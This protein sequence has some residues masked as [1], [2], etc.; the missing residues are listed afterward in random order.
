MVVCKKELCPRF[1]CIFLTDVIECVVLSVGAGAGVLAS[2]IAVVY[3]SPSCDVA[4]SNELNNFFINRFDDCHNFVI[5]GDF[6]YP[7]IDW[8]N[9]ICDSVVFEMFF[10]CM[11]DISSTQMVTACTRNNAI[12]DL[13][14]GSAPDIV[15]NVQVIANFP[16]ND[17]KSICASID[18]SA[19]CKLH[20]SYEKWMLFNKVK[21][22]LLYD[23]LRTVQMGCTISN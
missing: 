6:N 7:G 21:V 15:K 22:Q 20:I 12:L 4:Q 8:V 1:V 9:S 14:F 16:R 2:N 18:I 13:V 23:Y 10:D 17:H 5:L 11:M 3:R 19:L